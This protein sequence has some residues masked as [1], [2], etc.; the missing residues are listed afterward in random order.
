MLIC[1]QTRQRSAVSATVLLLIHVGYNNVTCT[2][3]PAVFVQLCIELHCW[4]LQ[5]ELD[6]HS[7][8]IDIT[9]VKILGFGVGCNIGLR[10]PAPMNHGIEF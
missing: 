7:W 9:R 10:I 4:A 1:L 8:N 6:T 3:A 5:H 2:S